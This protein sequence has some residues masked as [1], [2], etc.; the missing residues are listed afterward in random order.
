MAQGFKQEY[1]LDYLETFS[2]IAKISTIRILLIVAV[3]HK[4]QI[5]QLDVSNTFLHGDFHDIVYMTQPIGFIDQMYLDNVCLPKKSIY[6]LK[7]SPQNWLLN[8]PLI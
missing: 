7:Q 1:G 6:G 8:F 2:P 4:W 3:T 5:L